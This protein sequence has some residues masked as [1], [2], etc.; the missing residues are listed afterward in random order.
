VNACG[1]GGGRGGGGG[2]VR[3]RARQQQNVVYHSPDT[4]LQVVVRG[5]RSLETVLISSRCPGAAVTVEVL[6]VRWRVIGEG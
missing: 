3:G 4:A 5:R 1:V 6:V 2:E